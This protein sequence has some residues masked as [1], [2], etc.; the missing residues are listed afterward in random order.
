MA[1]HEHRSRDEFAR[2][3]GL[4]G[5][6]LEGLFREELNSIL[7]GEVGDPR[8]ECVRV[9]RVELSRDGSRARVWFVLTSEHTRSSTAEIQAAFA[10]AHGFLRGRLCDALP[11]KRAP[12]FQFR[13]DP[14]AVLRPS[15][16]DE[17]A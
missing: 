5:L 3:A 7:D 2:D 10:R 9:S 14:A 16:F 1:K 15:A 17:T 12:E 6:R 8:L 13:H 4:R 11:L